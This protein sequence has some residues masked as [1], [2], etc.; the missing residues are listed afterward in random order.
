MHLRP[1]HDCAPYICSESSTFGPLEIMG[2][3]AILTSLKYGTMRQ[4]G[5]LSSLLPKLPNLVQPRV[6]A[7]GRHNAKW[8]RRGRGDNPDPKLG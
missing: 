7:K 5:P 4:Q 3:V 2:Y 6:G 8:L 1:E